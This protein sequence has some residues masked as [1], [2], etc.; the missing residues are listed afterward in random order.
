MR[1]ENTPKKVLWVG[2]GCQTGSSKKLIDFAIQNTFKT[3]NLAME[4]IAGIATIDRKADEVGILE[5]CQ[6]NNYL[7]L[8]FDTETLNNIKVPN[9]SKI[10]NQEIRT[11][12]VA[13]AACLAAINNINIVRKTVSNGLLVTKQIVKMEGEK[14]AVTV[15]VA[16]ADLEYIIV[17]N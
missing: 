1:E 11:P 6:E 14:G 9:P 12:S 2:I 16:Q 3:H 4:S 5:L 15:A 10:V 17:L 8:T 13:E 7:L